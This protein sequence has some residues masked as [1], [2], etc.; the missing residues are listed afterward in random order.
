MLK[1]GIGQGPS[2]W[3]Q[4]DKKQIC[5]GGIVSHNLITRITAKIAHSSSS[6]YNAGL[7]PLGTGTIGY[8]FPVGSDITDWTCIENVSEDN[9]RYEGDISGTLPAFLN[10]APGPF[11]HDRFGHSEGDE[12]DMSRVTLQPEFVQGKVWGLIGIDEGPSKVLAYYGDDLRMK[13]GEKLHLH[14]IEI[15]FREDAELCVYQK[16]DNGET[17]SV[18][19]AGIRSMI[20]SRHPGF[21]HA[22]LIFTH[23]G[24]FGVV[25]GHQPGDVLL[26]LTPHVPLHLPPPSSGRPNFSRLTFSTKAPHILITSADG[27][28]LYASS[29]SS[30]RFSDFPVGKY[31]ARPTPHMPGGG[32]LVYSFSPQ[33]QFVVAHTR[34]ELPTKMEWPQDPNIYEVVCSIGD[35]N[36]NANDPK[37][38]M[39]LQG[40]GHLVCEKALVF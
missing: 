25:N 38:K 14:G 2:V 15:A 21:E 5:R 9:V 33:R 20:D 30:G 31:I 35:G 19:E 24:K 27:N 26:D 36:M 4:Q 18:W 3:W 17:Y 12:V 11:V 7:G 32:V 28:M 1:I 10:A 13:R 34:A 39:G 37:A 29:Y 40:D 16:Q 23:S 6:S 22:T 8:G